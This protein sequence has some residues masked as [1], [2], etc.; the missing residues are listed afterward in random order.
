M[1]NK[2]KKSLLGKFY[3]PYSIL[4]QIFPVYATN[5]DIYSSLNIYKERLQYWLGKLTTEGL[6]E[7]KYHG[8]YYITELGKKILRGYEEAGG[9]QL[10]RLENMRYKFPIIKNYDFLINQYHWANVDQLTNMRVIHMKVWGFTVRIFASSKNPQLEIC[11]KQKLGDNIFE[12]MYEAKLE[13]ELIGKII[14]RDFKIKLGKPTPSMKPEFAIPHPMAE[15]I[16]NVT[17]CSQIRAPRGTFNRSKGRNADWEVTDLRVATKILDMPNA[18][19]RIEMKLSSIIS[20][21]SPFLI[22]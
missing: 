15:A 20:N 3:L 13:V 18:I 11:C 10:I 4:R 2:S 1:K 17:Q 14:E 8:I 16:L 19:E 9:K 5:Y 7:R 12:M 21:S 6:I 22:L